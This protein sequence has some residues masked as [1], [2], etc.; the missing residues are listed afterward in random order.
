MSQTKYTGTTDVAR[1]AID[2]G[3]AT[4]FDFVTAKMNR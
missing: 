2:I 4:Q 3:S 1:N